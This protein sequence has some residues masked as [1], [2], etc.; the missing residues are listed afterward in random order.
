MTRHP[1]GSPTFARHQ[2]WLAAQR[3]ERLDPRP[4]TRRSDFAH[5]GV[6]GHPVGAVITP[7]VEPLA[8]VVEA[9]AVAFV[10][11]H[12]VEMIGVDLEAPDRHSVVDADDARV[13]D[14]LTLVTTASQRVA[15]Q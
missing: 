9:H 1:I 12:Y 5:L 4:S 15:A 2:L 13:F 3:D 10:I 7:R 11:V 14:A 6:V 8:V